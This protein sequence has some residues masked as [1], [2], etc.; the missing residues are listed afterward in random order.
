M[1]GLTKINL[2]IGQ[3][4]IKSMLLVLLIFLGLESFILLATQ[5]NSIGKGSY[6]LW[7]AMIY[8]F[9]I[10]PQETYLFFPM[11]ALLGVLL[12]LNYLSR[13][14]ELVIMRVS[15]ISPLKM[16]QAVLQAGVIAVVI[17]TLIG[18]G[19][20]PLGKSLAE[21]RKLIATS[22]EKALK[23][24]EGLWLRQNQ[25]FYH[26]KTV[27]SKNHIANISRYEFQQG[28][29]ISASFAQDGYFHHDMTKG[30]DNWEMTNIRQTQFSEDKAVSNVQSEGLWDL[31]IDPQLLR[32]SRSLPQEMTL[33]QLIDLHEYQQA[34]HLSGTVNE[35]V[36]WQRIC[37]PFASLLMMFLAV[38]FIFGPLRSANTGLRLVWGVITGFVFYLFNQLF[39]P[40]S[41]VLNFPPVMAAIFPLLIFGVAGIVLMRRI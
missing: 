25:N 10:L 36:F 35:M 12:G 1:E 19:L 34:N 28:K 17:M 21:K 33:F 5:L 37:Q 9:L 13:H 16:L 39:P 30:K 18:E 40:L 3:T 15:G 41:Q 20:G 22:T 2:Y 38:P 29:L 14:S 11:S 32:I 27:Y 24:D 6:T 23:T 4:V 8:V 7:Q 31:A 26:I